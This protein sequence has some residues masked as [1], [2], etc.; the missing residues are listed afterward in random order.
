MQEAFELMDVAS[1]DLSRFEKA[2]CENLCREVSRREAV[3]EELA[4]VQQSEEAAE[5]RLRRELERSL[6]LA[7]DHATRDIDEMRK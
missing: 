7:Y 5:G 1:E 6:G 3:S 2:A 4:E